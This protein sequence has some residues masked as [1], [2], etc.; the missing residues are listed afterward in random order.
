MVPLCI[1]HLIVLSFSAA[2]TYAPPPTPH[3][4]PK[5]PN[6]HT[7][8]SAPAWQIQIT[9]ST[10]IIFTMMRRWKQDPSWRTNPKFSGGGRRQQHGVFF[11]DTWQC[12]NAHGLDLDIVKPV[13]DHSS[14]KGIIN[15]SK[16][17]TGEPE[18]RAATGVTNSLVVAGLTC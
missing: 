15:L 10:I 18:R 4:P 12:S 9:I 6:T 17:A 3:P 5:P 2:N 13:A 7:R 8:S 1:N 16:A 11:K 14:V